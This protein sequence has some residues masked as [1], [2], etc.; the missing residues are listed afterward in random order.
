MVY[1]VNGFSRSPPCLSAVCPDRTE[2]LLSGG[3][4]IT[5][6]GSQEVAFKG[7]KVA[8]RSELGTLWC[9]EPEAVVI[10]GKPPWP[11]H[12]FTCR[13]VRTLK[14]AADCEYASAWP[15]LLRETPRLRRHRGL[16]LASIESSPVTSGFVICK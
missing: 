11:A 1:P 14:A 10:V 13:L 4:T 9:E 12:L 8:V 15:S 2:T 6:E 7:F 16:F 3:N 5:L